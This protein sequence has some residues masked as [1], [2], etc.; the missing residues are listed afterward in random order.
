MKGV[1][2]LK[3]LGPLQNAHEATNGTVSRSSMAVH[4]D[5]RM[6]AWQ[7]IGYINIMAPKL[8]RAARVG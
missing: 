6:A 4:G 1:K 3:T 8:R 7:L 2:I 5:K